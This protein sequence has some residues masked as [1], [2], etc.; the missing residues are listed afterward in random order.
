MTDTTYNLQ[1]LVL[2][3]YALL[4]EQLHIEH[5]TNSSEFM[6]GS[7][8]YVC[9]EPNGVANEV[10]TIIHVKIDLLLWI[11]AIKLGDMDSV[12]LEFIYRTYRLS[13]SHTTE[14][15]GTKEQYTQRFYMLHLS[16]FQTV[17]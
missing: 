9:L 16:I 5:L 1:L 13:R 10:T 15:E 17:Q 7:I 11:V 3:L 12:L 14:E 2:H 8:H 4:I 6:C